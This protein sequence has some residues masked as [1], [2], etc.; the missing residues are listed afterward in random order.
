MIKN[1]DLAL[2][3]MYPFFSFIIAVFIAQGLKPFIVYFQTK[4]FICSY[5]FASGGLPSS[6]SAG[7]TALALA[8]GIQEKFSSTIFAVTCAVAFIVMYDAANVRYYA[9]K[10]IELTKQIIKDIQKEKVIQLQGDIYEYPIKEV[11][12]H[13]WSEVFSGIALGILV[14]LLFNWI[15][16]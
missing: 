1:L 6:H 4:K 5:F 12:G 3:L 8:T 7:V 9:G 10:N 2:D 15:R 14:A 13:K 16:G 11:L